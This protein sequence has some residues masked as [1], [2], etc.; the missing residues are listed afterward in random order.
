VRQVRTGVTGNDPSKRGS[1]LIAAVLT[2]PAE[3]VFI[4]LNIGGLVSI[5]AAFL[6][7]FLIVHQSAASPGGGCRDGWC[8]QRLTTETV[9]VRLSERRSEQRRAVRR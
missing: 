9:I 7:L 5:V 3:I 4:L 2:I 1:A 6:V 8:E